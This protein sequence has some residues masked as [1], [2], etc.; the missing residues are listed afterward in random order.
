MVYSSI[1]TEI[2]LMC[3][4]IIIMNIRVTPNV[5]AMTTGHGETRAYLH[6]FNL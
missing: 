2:S 3:N 4:T 1:C 6:R 5:V